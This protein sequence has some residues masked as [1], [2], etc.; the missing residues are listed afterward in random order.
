MAF[1]IPCSK[2]GLDFYLNQKPSVSE[3]VG[4]GSYN[5]EKSVQ[6]VKE[7]KIPFGSGVR[8]KIDDPRMEQIKDLS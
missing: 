4:P 6:K 8:R 5:N 2:K 1:A 7:A 3:F